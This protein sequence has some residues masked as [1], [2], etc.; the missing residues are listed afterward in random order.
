MPVCVN[1]RAETEAVARSAAEWG[2]LDVLR[3]DHPW[4]LTSPAS[5]QNAGL[6]GI[7]ALRHGAAGNSAPYRR[8]GIRRRGTPPAGVSMDV[9]PIGPAL[10]PGR[11]RPGKRSGAGPPAG[12]RA[13]DRRAERCRRNGAGNGASYRRHGEQYRLWLARCMVPPLGGTVSAWQSPGGKGG[14]F[15]PPG[16]GPADMAPPIGGT[17]QPPYWAAQNG[18]VAPTEW[19]VQRTPNGVL[20]LPG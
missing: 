12:G 2:G 15:L 11:I 16:W 20:S 4:R 13:L 10:W 17:V 8:H 9:G 7:S 6:C 3:F 1:R 18:G 14:G 5:R 19:R